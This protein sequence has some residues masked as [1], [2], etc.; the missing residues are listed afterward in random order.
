VRIAVEV[1][2]EKSPAGIV[3][4]SSKIDINMMLFVSKL[5]SSRK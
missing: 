3:Q 1:R 4:R 5:T 2:R